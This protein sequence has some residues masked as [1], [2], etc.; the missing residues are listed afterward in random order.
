MS[1]LKSDVNRLLYKLEHEHGCT[2]TKG[3]NGHWKVRNG[4]AQIS[5]VS[6]PSDR[7][8]L[9]NIKGDCRRHLGIEL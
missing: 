2:V 1:G 5:V 9:L 8:V 3:R 7:R 6:S 4:T